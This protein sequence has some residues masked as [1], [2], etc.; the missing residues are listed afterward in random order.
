MV[1]GRTSAAYPVEASVPQGSILGP[2]LWNIYF[3]DLLQSLPVASAYADDCT[4]SQSY[5]RGAAADVIETA[6]RQLGD[7]MAW[8]RRWQVQFAAEK[9]QAILISRSREDA[10]LL[11]GKLRFGED[12]LAFKDSINIL[13]VEV[14]STLC[15]NRHL[16]TVAHRASLRVTL[17]RRVR[18]LLDADGLMKLYKAQVRPVMEYCPLSWMSSAQCHLSLLDKVQRR[19]ERLIHDSRSQQ[20]QQ[21]PQ[22]RDRQRRQQQQQQQH[23]QPAGQHRQLDSLEHRRRVGALTVLH[24]AQVQHTPHLA[25]L[26]V[27]WRRS[28]R[29]TRTAVSELLLEVPRAHTTRCQRA[30][31]CATAELWNTFTG[32]VDAGACLH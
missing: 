21:H 1:G 18:H 11:E 15:F 6:N 8:G 17:L 28:E 22:V 13:G 27:P 2:I 4:L 3:N 19:A 7:I 9:T 24:K 5:D 20:Q 10:R 26:R 29:T 30:F 25:A 31:T 16:E 23:Q 32:H 12:T 14:D